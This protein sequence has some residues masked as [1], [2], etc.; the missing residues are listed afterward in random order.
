MTPAGRPELNGGRGSP[1]EENNDRRTRHECVANYA[2]NGRDGHCGP[3]FIEKCSSRTAVTAII[4]SV[5]D[6]Q[7]RQS[8]NSAKNLKFS[9]NQ[10]ESADICGTAVP[11]SRR[12]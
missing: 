6:K 7:A 5:A 8:M 9:G 2:R 4:V 10:P 11:A 1:A 3:E 12:W